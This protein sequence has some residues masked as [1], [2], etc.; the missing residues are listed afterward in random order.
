M[1]E[2]VFL[3]VLVLGIGINPKITSFLVLM[4]SMFPNISIPCQMTGCRVVLF[5][6]PEYL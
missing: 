5:R 3:I 4:L 1:R 6:M 2:E